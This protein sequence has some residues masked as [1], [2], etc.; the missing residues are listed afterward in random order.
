MSNENVGFD[1]PIPKR[2]PVKGSNDGTLDI[3]SV[4]DYLDTASEQ[5]FHLS[6]E[7]ALFSAHAKALVDG[8]LTLDCVIAL[9][10]DSLPRRSGGDGRQ[11][12]EMIRMVLEGAARLGDKYLKPT[13]EKR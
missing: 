7:F 3:Q 9:L 1:L 11:S 6:K 12:K 5:V 4:V 2:R 10:Q 13:K 8:P